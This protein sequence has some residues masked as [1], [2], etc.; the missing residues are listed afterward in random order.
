MDPASASLT[1]PEQ[2]QEV[3][4]PDHPPTRPNPFDDTDISSR[5]RR[6]TSVPGS[7]AASLDPSSPVDDGSSSTTLDVDQTVSASAM[8][9]DG[10]PDA[11]RTPEQ[12]PSRDGTPAQPPSSRVTINLRKRRDSASPSAAHFSSVPHSGAASSARETSDLSENA[13][14]PGEAMDRAH[15][16][17]SPSP[18]SSS[19][20]ASPPVELVNLTEDDEDEGNDDMAFSATGL[21]AEIVG[22]HLLHMDPTLQFP[23]AEPEESLCD[24]LQRLTQ[25]FSTSESRSSASSSPP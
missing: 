13:E 3:A 7:P 19:L 17:I 25:Y 6:R 10:S 24:T 12:S 18:K 4:I 8:N 2:L 14:A 21:E 11:P 22:E 1:A 15:R 9:V 5:K 16:N 20:S 23:Y